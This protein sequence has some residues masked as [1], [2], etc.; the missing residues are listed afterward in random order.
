M[1]LFNLQEMCDG[2][3]M[4]KSILF[5]LIYAQL[6]H[7]FLRQRGS[8]PEVCEDVGK[9]HELRMWMSCVNLAQ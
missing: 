1:Y 3:V 8:K 4:H 9:F 2:P 6:D 7:S 5:I